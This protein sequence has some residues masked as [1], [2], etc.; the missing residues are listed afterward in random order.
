MSILLRI[1]VFLVVLPCASGWAEQIQELEDLDEW[2]TYYYLHPKP[3]EVARAL[4]AIDSKGFFRTDE[5]QAPLS[6]FFCEIFRAHPDKIQAWIAPYQ[7]R[8]GLHILYSA[9]WIAD[10]SESKE[11]LQALS[12]AAPVDSTLI[13]SLL[14]QAPPSLRET[15]VDSPAVLDYFWGRFMAS[16]SETPVVRVIDQIKL[17][18]VKGNLSAKLIGGA[19]QWSVAA[20]ARQHERVLS[21][22]KSQA[23]SADPE[24][25]Q[26]LEEILKDIAV[27]REGQGHDR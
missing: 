13:K 4:K 14:Q 12:A 9:L 11:A 1:I 24:T 2:M 20:N 3:E 6:G 10:S 25:R 15:T 27:E 17:A 23:T 7:G 22:V 21:I 18:N 16:G 5:V 19:A 8:T 26:A